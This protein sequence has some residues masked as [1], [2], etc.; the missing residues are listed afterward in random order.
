MKKQLIENINSVAEKNQVA[1]KVKEKERIENQKETFNKAWEQGFRKF[2]PCRDKSPD[3]K[4]INQ[5]LK[6]QFGKSLKEL[7]IN[8]YD[9]WELVKKEGKEKEWKE[10]LEQCITKCRSLALYGGYQEGRNSFLYYI[11]IDDKENDGKKKDEK[12]QLILEKFPELGNSLLV[13]TGSGYHIWFLS[14]VELANL[15]RKGIELRGEGLYVLFPF[16]KHPSGKIYE[17]KSGSVENLVKLDSN[18]A[19]ELQEFLGC[20][21]KEKRVKK[22]V[23]TEVRLISRKIE[24]ERKEAERKQEGKKEVPESVLAK[25]VNLLKKKNPVLYKI[26]T[27]GYEGEKRYQGGDG[28]NRSLLE[29]DF[30]IVVREIVKENG[31]YFEYDWSDIFS[32]VHFYL[33]GGKYKIIRG[34]DVIEIETKIQERGE[35]YLNY[36]RTSVEGRGWLSRLDFQRQ[37]IREENRKE[38]EDWFK[39]GGVKI[40][41]KP[42]GSGKSTTALQLNAEL[43]KKGEKQEVFVYLYKEKENLEEKEKIADKLGLRLREFRGRDETNCKAFSDQNRKNLLEQGLPAMDYCLYYCS[44]RSEC[45]KSGYLIDLKIL[46]E[47]GKLKHSEYDGFTATYDFFIEHQDK[48]HRI[49]NNLIVDDFE[50][51]VRDQ[52]VSF[53]EISRSHS[54]VI[55]YEKELVGEGFQQNEIDR[56]KDV[57][58]KLEQN[59]KLDVSDFGFSQIWKAEGQKKK[60]TGLVS[61]LREIFERIYEKEREKGKNQIP[62]FN[63]GK[64]IEAIR[65]GRY[66]LEKDGYGFY[67]LKKFRY[68]FNV[69]FLG[70][71]LNRELIKKTLTKKQLKK[72]KVLPIKDYGLANLKIKRYDVKVATS[73]WGYERKRDEFWK[74]VYPIVKQELT[75]RLVIFTYQKIEKELAEMIRNDFRDKKVWTS[76][77][78]EQYL[79]VAKE[80][81]DGVEVVITHYWGSETKGVNLFERFDK[82]IFVCLPIRN[83]TEFQRFKKALGLNETTISD[84]CFNELWQSIGRLRA[85]LKLSVEVVIIAN[86]RSKIA[87]AVMKKLE[88]F[89]IK[90]EEEEGKEKGEKIYEL[91]NRASKILQEMGG[92]QLYDLIDYTEIPI[93]KASIGAISYLN[94][95]G[96]GENFTLSEN[97]EVWFRKPKKGKYE[98][99]RAFLKDFARCRE[100]KMY[101]FEGW[102]FNFQRR[103]GGRSKK[104]GEIVEA[105][106][107]KI[108][109]SAYVQDV[110]LYKIK[111]WKR[112][113]I[114]IYKAYDGE[115]GWISYEGDNWTKQKLSEMKEIVSKFNE[116]NQREEIIRFQGRYHS[117]LSQIFEDVE[118]QARNTNLKFDS[119]F[120]YFLDFKIAEGKKIN[121]EQVMKEYLEIKKEAEKE[122]EKIR[123]EIQKELSKMKTED[124]MNFVIAEI[125]N[126]LRGEKEEGKKIDDKRKV[127]ITINLILCSIYSKVVSKAKKFE[128]QNKPTTSFDTS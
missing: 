102:R 7:G 121:P 66:Y 105:S 20:G 94:W 61:I 4:S 116:L 1:E 92:I 83:I 125:R 30:A 110:E 29:D 113:R 26:L 97:G 64:L 9:I 58:L 101:Q 77:D 126:D 122:E 67:E 68:D 59:R 82:A 43:K 91:N 75:G 15:N 18:S 12:L 79:K 128:A 100:L 103:G 119:S 72:L 28:L 62:C 112:K 63:I 23:K 84:D 2:I 88:R 106:I 120:L 16:S 33:T 57:L 99:E 31:L 14:D 69:L 96:L 70:T 10:F 85:F 118:K 19:K 95:V 36:I 49:G 81:P 89:E 56:V 34:N 93:G 46:E 41:Q 52:K 25:V 40:L 111:M 71:T 17:I 55:Q 78:L 48:F 109:F 39:N 86:L 3:V 80:I 76:D 115:K 74:N 5:F 73:Y 90:E 104:K 98:F 108:R 50:A 87:K 11:D 127:L 44:F 42:V 8:L 123:A 35:R 51:R 38:I 124:I 45:A 32:A 117:I 6:Q 22:E 47:L 37:K 54:L 27:C 21:D 65:D 13:E 107:S 114:L 53:Q 60:K 24:G